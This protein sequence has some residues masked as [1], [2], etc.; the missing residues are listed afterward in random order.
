VDGPCR[1]GSHCCS[2][3]CGG[4]TCRQTACLRRLQRCTT[5]SQCCEGRCDLGL[6]Q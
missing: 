6:C 3:V 2:G 4:T 5:T 1:L